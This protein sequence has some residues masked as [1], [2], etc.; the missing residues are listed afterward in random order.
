MA[1]RKTPG[2]GKDRRV[3][4][5]GRFAAGQR[6]ARRIPIRTAG[7]RLSVCFRGPH[8]SA[9]ADAAK[10]MGEALEKVDNIDA[11]FAFDDATARMAYQTAKAAGRQKDVRFIGVGGL[12]KQGVAYLSEGKLSATLVLPTGGPET[13]DAAVKILDGSQVP[14][15]LVLPTRIIAKD[16]K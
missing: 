10:L 15:N 8:R 6:I 16:S 13:I 3:A 2:Q 7:S 12:P 11:V 1:R 4:R 9:E 5:A 14:K